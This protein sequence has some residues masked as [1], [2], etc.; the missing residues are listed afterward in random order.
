LEFG[1]YVW[2]DS[3]PAGNALQISTRKQNVFRS[4]NKPGRKE[5]MAWEWGRYRAAKSRC[6]GTT[7]TLERFGFG[8]VTSVKIV[9]SSTFTVAFIPA[10]VRNSLRGDESNSKKREERQ[11]QLNPISRH[12]KFGTHH[13]M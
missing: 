12:A 6:V 3:I 4:A 10:Q 5:S 9:E 11:L 13:F 8:G 1:S 7:E 2:V